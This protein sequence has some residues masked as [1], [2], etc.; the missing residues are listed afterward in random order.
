MF[1]R[2]VDCFRIDDSDNEQVRINGMRYIPNFITDNDH[3]K[4][5]R[6]IDGEVWLDDLKR[7]VQHFGY[8]YDYKKR[9][10]DHSMYL[11]P[12][13][14]W[15]AVVADKIFRM[16]L[17]ASYPD[18]VIVN[19]YLPGQGIAD[20]VDCEPCFGR[21][22]VS[23]SLASTCIMDLKEKGNKANAYG[24]ILSP[25]SLLVLSG[26]A[27]YNW[28]HGIQGRTYDLFHGASVPRSRRVSLT[29]RTVIVP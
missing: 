19:E 1:D 15:A 20:H 11:G 29:F 4:L 16:G 26:E 23:L 13:P 17:M 25:K 24:L 22:I 9:Q 21:E 18:Q 14:T 10:L 12:L 5:L 3:S 27:R 6:A 7:R 28:T 8:K 2:T